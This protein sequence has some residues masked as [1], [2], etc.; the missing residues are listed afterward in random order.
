MKDF[1]VTVATLNVLRG[2]GVRIAIDDFGTGYSGL[3]FLQACPVDTLK[4]DRSFVAGLGERTGDTALVRAV[5]AFAK[6]LDLTITAE[7]VETEEQVA[8]LK[9]LEATP[10]PGV[11]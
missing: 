6:T 9:A 5:L 7:G 2:I 3:S 11:L 10:R 4:I 1:T 8:Q